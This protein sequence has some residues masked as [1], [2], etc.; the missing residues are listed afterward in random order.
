MFAGNAVN[1]TLIRFCDES[2]EV[3]CIGGILN[4]LTSQIQAGVMTL[5]EAKEA[6]LLK[7]IILLAS[8]SQDFWFDKFID[9]S[10]LS[11]DKY[12]ISHGII[13]EIDTERKKVYDEEQKIPYAF[14]MFEARQE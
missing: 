13:Y 14:R 5:K 12:C 6:K 11:K 4:C 7:Q 8:T 1:L 9:A 2:K 3:M 10:G